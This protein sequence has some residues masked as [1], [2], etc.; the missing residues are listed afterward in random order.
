MTDPVILLGTQSNGETLPVQVNQF[1]QL[2]A[3]GL[4][5]ATGPEGPEG[6]QGPPG[7]PGEILLP[8]DPYEGALL[9][10]LDGGLAWVGSPPVPIPPGVFGPIEA[11]DP[12]TGILTIEGEIP[13]S[14]GNGV[15]LWQCSQE[16]VHYT[17]EANVSQ[18]WSTGISGTNHPSADNAYNAKLLFNGE[19]NLVQNSDTSGRVIFS[20]PDPIVYTRNVKVTTYFTGQ[21]I[22]NEGMDSQQTITVSSTKNEWTVHEGSGTLHNIILVGDS[23]SPTVYS[24]KVD[25][26]E[27]LDYD[28]S[29]NMRVNQVFDGNKILG[30]SLPPGFNFVA[31]QYLIVPAQKVAPWVLR[32][33]DTTTDI[34]ISPHT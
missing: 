27:L 5:G 25:D 18:V 17:P 3:Q 26:K 24:Y 28:K 13:A 9:G 2:V 29:I 14:V 12:S 7:P 4:D 15:Y 6:P 33:V 32:K 11:W 1:G 20:L 10:W 31:G 8:P 23:S 21:I 22:M 30:A 16:G 34:D 19:D